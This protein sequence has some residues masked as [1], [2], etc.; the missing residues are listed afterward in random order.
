MEKRVISIGLEA[1]S[2]LP[3]A[4]VA[5]AAMVDG[6][7]ESS[8]FVPV[9]RREGRNQKIREVSAKVPISDVAF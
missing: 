2:S 6:D 5:A 3:G 9:P 8:G 1:V 7:H 4:L